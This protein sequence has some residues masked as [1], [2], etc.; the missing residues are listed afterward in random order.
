[1]ASE[2]GSYVSLMA[3]WTGPVVVQ[4]ER[5]RNWSDEQMLLIVQECLRLAGVVAQVAWRWAIGNRQLY[6]WRK[7]LLSGATG[8][9]IPCEII[10]DS[11]PTPPG[12]LPP[13]A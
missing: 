9:S 4:C 13:P 1:M 3:A 11:G 7:Q 12:A 8:S 6:T 5:S 10:G 2:D